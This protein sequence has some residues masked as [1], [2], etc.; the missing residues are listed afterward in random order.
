[1]KTPCSLVLF[2]NDLRLADNPALLSAIERGDTVIPVYVWPA[3]TEGKWAIGEA[4]RWWL[5][6][7][8]VDLIGQLGA[9]GSRLVIKKGGDL[10]QL[11]TLI[12]ET[13]AYTVRWNRRYDPEGTADDQHM[14]AALREDGIAVEQSNGNV[15]FE[16]DTVQT[17][18]GSHYQVFTSFWRACQSKP[19]PQYPSMPPDTL[20]GPDRWPNGLTVEGLNLLPDHEWDDG[21]GGN[22]KPGETSAKKQLEQISGRVVD[23]Y[24]LYRDQPC[25]A[26][27]S[28][29]S[30]HLHFGEISASQI[31]QTICASSP[32]ES[33]KAYLRQLGW[34]DFSIHVLF[35][36]PET[37]DRPLKTEFAAFPWRKDDRALRAWQQGRTGYPLVDAGM[38]ELR[39]TGWMHNRVRMVAGSFLVKQLLI[40]WQEGA[41]WFWN[42]L[43]DADLA[44]NTMGWQWVAGCGADAAPYFRVFNPIIQ[45]KRFDADGGYIRRWVPEL[46][47]LPDK[48]L[49]TPWESPSGVLA[50]AGV[51]LGKTY[52]V[53]II[54]HSMAR[55]RAIDAYLQMRK[56]S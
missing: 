1:M 11:R 25:F 38:R 2:R 20:K 8:L 44:N 45:S 16:P 10:E 17:C 29:L 36:R 3:D 52:P 28:R 50:D 27:T 48:H 26:G 31:W 19:G 13:G 54:D 9:L 32:N 42:S 24:A 6:H 40:S 53:P 37:V 21:L 33:R 47:R 23:D 51:V 55:K 7:S 22:W 12:R 30:A 5:H 4:A 56:L 43:V 39:R 35:H 49:H 18:S 46:A 15:L 14:M 34:R 41:R